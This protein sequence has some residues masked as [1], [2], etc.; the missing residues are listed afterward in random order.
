MPRKIAICLLV[1]ALLITGLFTACGK[2]TSTAT[3][4][5][6]PTTPTTTPSPTTTAQVNWWDK[7]G[8]PKY[9]GT[10]SLRAWP[11]LEQVFFDPY[12]QSGFGGY[13]VFA[14]C[15]ENP[16]Y[17]NWYV[18]RDIQPLLT[19][20]ENNLS[21]VQGALLDTWDMPDP[22]TVV[23]HVRQGVHWWNKPPAN[24]RQLVAS[25]IVAHYERVMGWGGG[26]PNFIFASTL[27]EIESVTAQDEQTVVFKLKHANFVAMCQTFIEQAAS[28]KIE[29][30]LGENVMDYQH[31]IGTGPYWVKEYVPGASITF[32]KNPDYWAFDERYPE[33]RLPY[34]DEIKVTAIPDMTTAISALRSGQLDMLSGL[35]WR[36]ADTLAKSN[37]ELLQS[38]VLTMGYGIQC[39]VDQPPFNDI[40]LRKALQM[41]I[42]LP[43]L[44]QTHYGGTVS[45]EPAG[46][47]TPSDPGWYTPFSEW[48]QD[49]KDE[50]TY[51]P[52][53]AK[54]LLAEAGYSSQNPL[55]FKVVA[56]STA[57]LEQL[58]I[59]QSMFKE[60]GIEM[61][62]DTVDP[63]A[64]FP[65]CAQGL[66]ETIYFYTT[67][68]ALPKQVSVL[69][70]H[71]TRSTMNFLHNQ[72]AT[73]DALIESYFTTTTED[74]AKKAFLE[75]EQY[76]LRQHYDILTVCPQ[77]YTFWSPNLMGYT[78]EATLLNMSNWVPKIWKK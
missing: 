6:T 2:P 10:L 5:T 25:D 15:M 22:T 75:V 51:N 19:T 67:G 41:S 64:L 68:L 38:H 7:F 63:G 20:Q 37:P 49:L 16:F 72:D 9:G 26:P 31:M 34:F 65:Y 23:A 12:L 78:G 55:K 13:S 50:Y 32:E 47:G 17:T 1:T 76:C 24:G 60:V 18:D 36:Q 77:S 56:E 45:P 58:Q 35:D 59:L 30:P 57:D 27:S 3:P 54:R 66:H 74:E 4:T 21:L 39:R 52:E 73:L 28:T 46:I 43:L 62:I 33:N 48:P 29:Y 42:N 61:S 44:A 53:E 14:I 40:N 11:S 69:W 8:P 71:S 70:R